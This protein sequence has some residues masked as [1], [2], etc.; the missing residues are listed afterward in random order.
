MSKQWLGSCV[1]TLYQY[2]PLFVYL[3]P[4]EHAAQGNP[5]LTVPGQ[6]L[7][8]PAARL[9]FPWQIFPLNIEENL[10]TRC[11]PVSMPADQI[12]FQW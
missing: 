7:S 9:R 5:V 11:C 1:C 6:M 12:R 4:E 10:Q 3:Y 2:T 8:M